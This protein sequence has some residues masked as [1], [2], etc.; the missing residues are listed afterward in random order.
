MALAAI[1]LYF[2]G[3]NTIIKAEEL[4]KPLEGASSSEEV[5][6]LGDSGAD[7]FARE[8]ENWYVETDGDW[9]RRNDPVIYLTGGPGA[10]DMEKPQFA[11]Q[12]YPNDTL[13][14]IFAQFGDDPKM[15]IMLLTLFFIALLTL[16]FAFLV[17]MIAPVARIINGDRGDSSGGARLVAW[18]TA[19]LGTGSIAGLGFATYANFEASELLIFAGLPGW[20]RWTVIAGYIAGLLGLVTLVLTIRTRI[21]R[22]LPI[23]TLLGLVSTGLAGIAL[24]VGLAIIG[25][26]VAG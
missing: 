15:L 16:P 8:P 12:L 3:N 10:D 17:Y 23:G 21:T 11:G 26:G 13:P 20:A 14:R 4:F 22:Y 25:F 6:S 1:G 18:L 5:A 24:A 9:S 7:L 2:V 19:L